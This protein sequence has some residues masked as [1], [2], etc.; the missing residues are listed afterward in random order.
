M[1]LK[2]NKNWIEEGS[3]TDFPACR[4]VWSH[5]QTSESTSPSW[6]ATETPRQWTVSSSLI[7]STR[8]CHFC[9]STACLAMVSLVSLHAVVS[10]AT[11]FL[12]VFFWITKSPSTSA[13]LCTAV[14]GSEPGDIRHTNLRHLHL[15]VTNN[16]SFYISRQNIPVSVN[17]WSASYGWRLVFSNNIEGVSQEVGG[18]KVILRI[19]GR[20]ALH[21]G[22]ID[23][24]QGRWKMRPTNR[25]EI[26]SWE[27]CHTH[28]I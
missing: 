12:H 14:F 27:P 25:R 6:T 7:P 22:G 4:D 10:L 18:A 15:P 24:V 17:H 28:S 1:N 3:L 21:I 26:G 9:Q 23:T 13:V 20:L 19:G 5:S 16:G 11:V 2:W 8:E